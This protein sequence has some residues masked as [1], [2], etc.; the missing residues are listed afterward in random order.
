[1]HIVAE[2]RKDVG[3]EKNSQKSFTNF[4]ETAVS[5]EKKVT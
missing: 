4:L 2:P 1:M 3:E 5:T